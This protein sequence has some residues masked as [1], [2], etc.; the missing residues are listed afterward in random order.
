VLPGDATRRPGRATP[1]N[2]VDRLVDR[3]DASK[4]RGGRP[5][6]PLWRA[7]KQDLAGGLR[8]NGA[9]RVSQAPVASTRGR[10]G[11]ITTL[12]CGT[13]RLTMLVSHVVVSFVCPAGQHPMTRGGTAAAPGNNISQ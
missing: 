10:G 9:H 12:R 3:A 1:G 8:K 6:G 4:L 11:S 5:V 7:V 2:E 13:P